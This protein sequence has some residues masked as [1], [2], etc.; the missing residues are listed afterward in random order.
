MSLCLAAEMFPPLKALGRCLGTTLSSGYQLLFVAGVGSCGSR[1]GARFEPDEYALLLY[2]FVEQVA[3][4]M[5][6]DA[7]YPRRLEQLALRY[8]ARCGE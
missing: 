2:E 7:R 1:T 6:S 8:V 5:L 3:H 4:E